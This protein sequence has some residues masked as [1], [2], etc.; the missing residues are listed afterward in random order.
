MNPQE[1]VHMRNHKV[2]VILTNI[3]AGAELCQAQGK[4]WLDYHSIG[5]KSG[6]KNDT[7]LAFNSPVFRISSI[8]QGFPYA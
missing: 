8:N 3:Q 1:A 6:D 2:K 4:F 5:R 7:I